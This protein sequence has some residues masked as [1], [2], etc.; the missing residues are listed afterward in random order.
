MNQPI[1]T[2]AEAKQRGLKFYFTGKPHK[3]GHVSER[4]TSTS[5]CVECKKEYGRE[6]AKTDKYKRYQREY[7]QVYQ[8]SDKHIEYRES[9]EFKEWQKEYR[10]LDTY[11]EYQIQYRS[12][13]E[14]KEYK[15]AYRLGYRKSDEGKEISRAYRNDYT[16]SR[17]LND[18]LF[19]STCDIRG[20]IGSSIKRGG[21]KKSSKT[22]LILGCSYEEFKIHIETQFTE[23]MSWDNYGEW[24]YDHVYPVSLARDEAHMIE[25][26]HYS[27]FQPLWAVD[28][29]RK[30]NKI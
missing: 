12:T 24:H 9:D 17:K 25:L 3:C 22:A 1:I 29:I 19:K 8:K 16:K 27:N 5:R 21:F 4:Y 2:R 23:G 28:N 15:R 14:Y 18:L 30:G 6:Y 11:K 26:N 20:L 10:K 7:Q 13:E